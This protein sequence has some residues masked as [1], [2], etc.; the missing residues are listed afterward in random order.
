MKS[1]LFAPKKKGEEGKRKRMEIT[2]SHIT[3]VEE[4]KEKRKG[5]ESATVEDNSPWPKKKG[6]KKREEGRV[7]M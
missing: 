3:L 5:G 1:T 2:L 6:K 7:W 4:G